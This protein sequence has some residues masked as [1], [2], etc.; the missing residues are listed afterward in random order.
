MGHSKKEVKKKPL[1]LRGAEILRLNLGSGE[2]KIAGWHN[3]DRKFGDE[4]YPLNIADESVDVIRASHLL[5]HFPYEQAGAVVQ[6]WVSKLKPGG[7]LKIAVPDFA[8]L[9]AGYLAEAPVNIQGVVMGGHCDDN[10]HHKAIFDREALHDVMADAG[11]V[12]ICEWESDHADCS[13]LPVSCNLM[14][15]KPAHPLSEMAPGTISA[16]LGAP[17]FGPVLH[18]RSA[19][20]AF[21]PLR[22]PYTVHQGCFWH[23]NLSNAIERELAKPATE[24]ILTCDFDS[25]FCP[26]DVIE[27]YRLMQA[28]P[29]ASAIV[30]LQ[31]KRDM[32]SLL[33]T[34]KDKDG[35]AVTEIN[36]N[37]LHQNLV[38]VHTGHFG[39]TM[40]RADVLRRF[41][42]PWMNDAPAPD[43][44][45][46]EGRI[47]ADISFWHNWRAFGQKLYLAPK[48]V[49]GH[50]EE[51][52][53]WP[54]KTLG[55]VHQK[56]TDFEAHGKPKGILR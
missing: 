50:A 17:R 25:V 54:S 53:T 49:I 10:D 22:I 44:T 36:L 43:G 6:H 51:V 42:R 35:N 37:K 3:L 14:G 30:A 47:D 56:L 27:L 29:A 18:F 41:P 52:V 48:V 32:A 13:S 16:V 4:C 55:V 24:Y 9:A 26:D 5:E 34:M 20:T 40:F 39:L 23:Q 19:M 38:E 45:W 31:T 11:L 8:K 28:Y 7:I 46:G 33:F 1:D 12:R 21:A 15:Y 2:N